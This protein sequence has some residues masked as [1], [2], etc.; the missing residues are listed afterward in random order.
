[1]INFKSSGFLRN[2]A[3]LGVLQVANYILPLLTLPYL[4]R[5]LGVESYG[6]YALSVAIAAYF[7]IIVEYSFNLLAT[8]DVAKNKNNLMKLSEIFSCVISIKAILA[9]VCFT[10]LCLIS[11]FVQKLH[12]I[13]YLNAVSF[14]ITVGYVLFPLWLYQGVEKMWYISVIN[15]VYKTLYLFSV[16]L[17]IN[18]SGDTLVAALLLSMSFIMTGVTGFYFALKHEKIRFSIYSWNVYKY[19]LT[20]GFRVFISNLSI[21]FYLN[22]AIPIL[23]MFASN[24]SVGLYSA[25]HKIAEA[26]KGV[27][28][29][30]SQAFFPNVAQKFS[31]NYA[32]GVSSLLNFLKFTMGIN[33]CISL[34][35]FTMSGFIVNLIAGSEYEGAGVLL[36]ILSPLPFLVGISNV[37]GIQFMVN[38][39]ME[40]QFCGVLI[41]ASIISLLLTLSFVPIYRETATASILVFIE[42]FVMLFMIAFS[43]KRIKKI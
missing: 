38:N 14:L 33:L 39:G 24:Q 5:T 11:L 16:F 35:L 25:A 27:Y 19:Y 2:A 6:A 21:S 20:S 40:K 43:I 31:R 12:S 4:L 26:A 34:C 15:I 41:T 8:K 37:F 18:D 22:L 32:D 30:L 36:K 42:F 17:F 9:L 10:L 28:A 7:V 13:F 1:M 23:G 3:S 29:P